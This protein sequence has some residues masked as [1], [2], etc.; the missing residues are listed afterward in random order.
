M[1]NNE[2]RLTGFV[3]ADSEKI[4]VK[5]AAKFAVAVDRF[6]GKGKEAK[7]DIFNVSCW[8]KRYESVLKNV[9]KGKL[10]NVCGTIV[11]NRQEDKVYPEVYLDSFQLVQIPEAV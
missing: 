9:K 3:L 10:V 4:G 5:N 1:K 6:V 8:T 7:T 2:I 11:L